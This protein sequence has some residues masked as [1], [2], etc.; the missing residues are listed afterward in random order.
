MYKI[1]VET[2]FAAAHRLLGYQG[3]CERIHGH[4][5]IVKAQ[6]A[7]T[8]LDPIGM[9][10]D[11]K[12]LGQHV[13]SIIEKFDHQFLNEIHPFD[14]INPSSENLANY[15]FQSLKDILPSNLKVIF[16]EIKESDKYSAIYSED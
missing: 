9:A 5:W 2:K 8:E 6:I 3:N 7:S 1:S 15:I 4:N 11:F 10:Y 13:N 16:V 12:E 14:K